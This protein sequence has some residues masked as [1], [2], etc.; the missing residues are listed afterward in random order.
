MVNDDEND[1]HCVNCDD[2]FDSDHGHDHDHGRDH[3]LLI[4]DFVVY[5]VQLLLDDHKNID[6]NIDKNHDEDNIDKV[7]SL[8]FEKKKINQKC[9]IM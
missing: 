3:V 7:R 6:P 2:Y 5:I 9:V 1:F 4:V 8:K